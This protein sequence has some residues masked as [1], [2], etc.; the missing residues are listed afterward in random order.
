[1][2]T[3]FK[4]KNTV[5]ARFFAFCNYA[6]EEVN[7]RDNMEW[8]V[9]IDKVGSFENLPIVILDDEDTT[10]YNDN[11]EFTDYLDDSKGK[12]LENEWMEE[13]ERR[14]RTLFFPPQR[15]ALEMAA[16]GQSAQLKYSNINLSS[17][18]FL[19][20]EAT[21]DHMTLCCCSLRQHSIWVLVTYNLHLVDHIFGRNLSSGWHK[22][23]GTQQIPENY[24]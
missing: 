15:I 9:M 24:Q 23:P 8:F 4:A 10:Y 7:L 19:L 16:D 20:Q 12:D 5:G 11:E 13:E 17:N 1:M 21:Q 14:V 22:L 6:G 2:V 3:I 18:H